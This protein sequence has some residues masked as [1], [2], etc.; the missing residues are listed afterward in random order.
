MT[1][2]LSTDAFYYPIYDTSPLFHEEVIEEGL[3]YSLPPPP[4]LTDSPVSSPKIVKKRGRLSLTDDEIERLRDEVVQKSTLGKYVRAL[5]VTRTSYN[6]RMLAKAANVSES[7]I[8]EVENEKKYLG[9][10]T[11]EKVA[12]VLGVAAETLLSLS[13]KRPRKESSENTFAAH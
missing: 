6:Q 10:A 4:E 7:L 12:K 1:T 2:Y 5:R 13:R 3:L 11:A 9:P 8:S